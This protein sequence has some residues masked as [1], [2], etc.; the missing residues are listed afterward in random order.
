MPIFKESDRRM[1]EHDIQNEIRM[2]ISPYGTYFRAN[3]GQAWTGEA[4]HYLPNGDIL[5]KKGRPF[6][7]GLPKGFPDLFG[8]TLQDGLPVFTGLE[9]K[10]ANGRIRKEQQHMID[11][12]Q[13]RNCKA[14]IVRSAAEAVKLLKG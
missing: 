14:G 10:A 11:F 4:I 8:F 9:V 1:T 2:A 6:S 5:I 13:S 12:M 7:T 3:V